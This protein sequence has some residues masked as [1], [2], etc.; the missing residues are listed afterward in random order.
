MAYKRT[1]F[2]CILWAL[3]CCVTGVML[4]VYTI[5]FWKNEVNTEVG[6]NTIVF[7][8]LVFL[9]LICS[10]LFLNKAVSGWVRKLKI[11]KKAALISESALVFCI[12]I[13]AL[14]YRIYLYVQYAGT[15]AEMTEYFIMASSGG[16]TVGNQI[17]HGAS[18]LYTTLLHIVLL[19]NGNNLGAAVCF[20]IALQILTLILAYFTVR[21]LAGKT[22][23]CIALS[24][25]AFSSVYVNRIFDITPEC[26]FLMLYLI[27]MI[28]VGS[29]VKAYGNGK[30]SAFAS[31]WF[32]AFSGIVVGTLTYFDAVSL[33]LLI[34][35][36][37]LFT[38]IPTAQAKQAE[39]NTDE[40]VETETERST[41][42][43]AL[44]IVIVFVAALITVAG[45]FAVDAYVSRK[46]YI[47]VAYA[48]YNLYMSHLPIDYVFHQTRYYIIE[49]Y[50]QVFLA[51]FLILSFW[52]SH[53]SQNSSPWI[54]LMLLM[55]PSPLS[56]AGVL[57][58]QVFSIF[59]WSVLA[60]LGVQQSCVAVTK[61][62]PVKS[63]ET[64]EREDTTEITGVV[65]TETKSAEPTAASET[66]TAEP[67]VSKPRYIENPLP[68]PKKHE[69]REMDFQ[70]EVPPDKMKFDIDIKPGDDFDI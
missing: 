34:F 69:K 6:Y 18:S 61:T 64:D 66:K 53:K 51:A 5:L 15:S 16:L 54:I 14:C 40:G 50:I 12:C 17:L 37:A 62:E 2:S 13:A 70:Y 29:F 21:K 47:N 46:A 49:C 28:I 39:S 44:I 41:G 35:L 45:I 23:S 33:T 55:A 1:W 68:L 8:V 48:W 57:P 7:G 10:Y 38:A 32:A 67:M 4:A 52:N 11:S 60:G 20:Q 59:I 19:F 31:V 42:F 24:I 22:A 58:Y 9:L 25:L 36:P 26:M 56:K 65:A 3:F 63:N 27:G 43:S 30:L